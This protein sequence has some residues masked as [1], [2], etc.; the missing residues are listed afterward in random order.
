[1]TYNPLARKPSAFTAMTGF[2]VQEFEELLVD[3][4]LRD[5]AVRQEE[6]AGTP[7]RR[8]GGRVQ[9]TLRP[10]GADAHDAGVATPVPDRRR[11]RRPLRRG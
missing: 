5:E 10:A 8:A 3:L 4:R 7:R 11:G 2:A 9:A 6:R 1:M